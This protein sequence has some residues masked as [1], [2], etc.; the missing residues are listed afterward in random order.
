M[1][2][3]CDKTNCHG[4]GLYICPLHPK[5][6]M[7]QH[8]FIGEREVQVSATELLTEYFELVSHP[9]TPV[10]QAT[11]VCDQLIR[12]N[13]CHDKIEQTYRAALE[14]LQKKMAA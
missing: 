13:V 7:P 4:C 10:S 8:T 6:I 1:A 5:N 2:Q 14:I 11:A 3:I 12:L 9:H